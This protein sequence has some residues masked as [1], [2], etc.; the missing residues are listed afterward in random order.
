VFKL[1]PGPIKNLESLRFAGDPRSEI[2]I[3]AV[4][5]FIRYTPIDFVIISNGGYRSAEQQNEL[6]KKGASQ[7][8]GFKHKSKHQSG[9]AV[10]LVPWINSTP[11]WDEKH[12]SVL[13]GA[14]A[15]YLNIKGIEFIGGFDWDGDGSLTESF[16]DPC[17]FQLKD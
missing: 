8:D 2:L 11:T 10:D 14:F 4:K 6:Y 15:N 3:E 7:L 17:H 1:G 5:D 9:L 16:Y 13:A 12:T